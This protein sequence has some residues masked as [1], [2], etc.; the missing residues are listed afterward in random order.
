MIC[1]RIGMPPISIIGFGLNWLSSLMREPKPPARRTTFVNFISNST[2]LK[3][4][5]NGYYTLEACYLFKIISGT[6][7]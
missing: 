5:V 7:V 1:Q 6:Y 3:L 4:L 2:F